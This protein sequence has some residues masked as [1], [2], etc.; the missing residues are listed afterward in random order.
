VRRL[1]LLLVAA[2]LALALAAGSAEAVSGGRTQP[3]AGTPYVAWL[4]IGCTGTLIAPDR[5][6][7]AGHCLDGFSPLG[8]SVLVGTDGN[9]LAQPGQD[10]FAA[11][12]ANGGIPARGFAVHPRFKE[13]FPFAHRAPQN[14]IAQHD[15]G[16]ILLA[17]PVSGITPVKLPA[18][19]DRAVQRIGESA[20][21]LGYG[22]KGPSVTSSPHTLQRGTMTVI[23][24]AKCR[25]AYPH[26]II[27]SELCARDL[28]VHR[29]LIQACAGDSGGPLI[30]QTAQGPVQIGITSWGP[31]VKDAKC[32][33]RPLPGV[34]MRTASF[35]PFIAEANPVIEPYPAA[36]LLDLA[37]E[38]KV[39]GVGRVGETLTCNPPQFAGSRSKLSYRWV[40]NLRTVSRT[41]TLKVTREMIGHNMGCSVTA[42][43]AS[44][45]FETIAGLVNR[46]RVAG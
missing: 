37:S 38:P 12:I 35:A 15:V 43:N 23:S 10:R 33:R 16:V 34:T 46:V 3:I 31:E 22:L 45:H 27:A 25:R 30:R 8:F 5:V 14:A 24:P 32:G 17:R 9:A 36:P 11:A 21:I 4:P 39:T 41:P 20:T 26:A 19:T 7:T 6:L 18:A 28:K 44:G 29:P 42:R 2:G 13:S 40:L 1:P